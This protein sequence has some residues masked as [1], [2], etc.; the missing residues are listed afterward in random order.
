LLF[1]D[2]EDEPNWFEI[3]LDSGNTIN[4]RPVDD[5]DNLGVIFKF[6]DVMMPQEDVGLEVHVNYKHPFWSHMVLETGG[7]GTVLVLKVYEGVDHIT[8][9]ADD[10]LHLVNAEW[11]W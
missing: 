2:V 6:D 10:S 3:H 11:F 9:P 7:E 1:C 8:A 4:F 5:E